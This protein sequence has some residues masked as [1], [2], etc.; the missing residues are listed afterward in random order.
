MAINPALVSGPD[1]YQVPAPFPGEMLLCCRN[2]IKLDMDGL[3][4]STRKYE[5]PSLCANLWLF[6][7]C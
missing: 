6:R 2:A 3:Q 5:L 4:T 1:G 7:T